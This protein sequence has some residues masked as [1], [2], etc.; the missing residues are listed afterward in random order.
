MSLMVRELPWPGDPRAALLELSGAI[1]PGGLEP[2]GR[3]IERLQGEG[4]VHVGLDLSGIRYVSSS[5]F[6]LL[7]RHAQALAERGGGIA[8]LGVPAKVRVVL[9]LLGLA[10]C[11]S[12]VCERRPVVSAA[13]RV[14]G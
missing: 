7:V 13:A 14:A 11:F 5:G 8:L 1:D 4:R 12:A 6:G 10:S 3:A 9:E 2:F